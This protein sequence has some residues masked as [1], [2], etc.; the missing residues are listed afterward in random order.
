[1]DNMTC[2][3]HLQ[4]ILE[5]QKLVVIQVFKLLPEYIFFR[6][7]FYGTTS[8]ATVVSVGPATRVMLCCILA[9]NIEICSLGLSYLFSKGENFNHRG[10]LLNG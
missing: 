6:N 3:R 1:M 2:T 10:L 8:L 7:F 5:H 9:L 4:H